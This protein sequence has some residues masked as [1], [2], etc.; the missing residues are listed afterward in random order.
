MCEAQVS[1]ILDSWWSASAGNGQL[2]VGT[3]QVGLA[4]R[5]FAAGAGAPL[6]LLRNH[7]IDFAAAVAEVAAIAS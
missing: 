5:L 3:N 4:K 7:A 6:P 2:A 1:R